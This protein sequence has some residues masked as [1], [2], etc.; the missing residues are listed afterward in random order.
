M[1]AKK[2]G[3]DEEEE[4]HE[5]D[6]EKQGSVRKEDRQ[7]KKA[8]KQGEEDDAKCQYELGL[9]Y[10]SGMDGTKDDAKAAEHFLAAATMGL[11]VG[12]F[13]VGQCFG[14][15]IGVRES[16]KDSLKWFVM[17][18]EQGHADSQFKVALCYKKGEGVKEDKKKAAEWF[19]KAAEQGHFE[20]QVNLDC[21]KREADSEPKRSVSAWVIMPSKSGFVSN[22]GLTFESKSG[23]TWYCA[24]RGS[25]GWSAGVHEW[26][27]V[28]EKRAANISVGI[29]RGD[30]DFQDASR[31][32]DKRYDV[33][34][35]YGCAV[36]AKGMGRPVR[37]Q[38][39]VY[40]RRQ[41]SLQLDSS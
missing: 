26:V 20:A 1:K 12:Q 36:E 5:K 21:M 35:G 32:D 23:K 41:R 25:R 10:R 34:C 8:K 31:N 14:S 27:V 11:A 19:K 13:T 17:A 15:G 7:S 22:E 33:Y 16:K 24:T 39:E 18:A 28:L 9:K 40:K 6:G 2:G 30:I 4:K 37:F 29:A 3:D 38:S